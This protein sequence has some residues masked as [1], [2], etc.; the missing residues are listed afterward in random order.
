ME[1]RFSFRLVNFS[2][3]KNIIKVTHLNLSLHLLQFRDVIK[4][5][6]YFVDNCVFNTTDVYLLVYS[7][8]RLVR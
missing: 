4:D 5:T 7:S 2:A 8:K 1:Y 6:N 3:L